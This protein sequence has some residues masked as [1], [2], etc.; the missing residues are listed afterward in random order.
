MEIQPQLTMLQKT[1]LNVEGL[2]RELDPNLDLWVT[3]RPFL[4]NW[5]KEQLG[6]KSLIHR[7]KK[8]F[9]NWLEIAPLFPTLLHSYLNNHNRDSYTIIEKNMRKSMKEM[10]I[11]QDRIVIAIVLIS[12]AITL[13]AFSLIQ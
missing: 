12:I 9:P 11:R 13:M 1:L 7:I 3:A 6:P 5:L 10:K 8:E 4:E 2:G